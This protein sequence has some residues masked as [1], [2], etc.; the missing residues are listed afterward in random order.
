MSFNALE[1]KKD[2]PS[3]KKNGYNVASTKLLDNQGANMEK[4]KE[5]P[6]SKSAMD[7]TKSFTNRDGSLGDPRKAMKK[8]K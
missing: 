4:A 5:K 2:S 6:L 1:M 3:N 8:H 7:I